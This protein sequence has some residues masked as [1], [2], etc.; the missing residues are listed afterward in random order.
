MTDL[1]NNHESDQNSVTRYYESII[2][3]VPV[4]MVSYDLNLDITKCNPAFVELTGYSKDRL[5]SMNVKDF[6]FTKV[7][8]NGA[9][10]AIR[11]KKKVLAKMWGTF[12]SGKKVVNTYTLPIMDDLGKVTSFLGVYIDVTDVAELQNKNE[13]LIDENPCAILVLDEKKNVTFLNKAFSKITG[14]SR[15]EGLRMNMRSFNVTKRDGDDAMKAFQ[16]GQ[17]AHGSLTLNCP[18]GT[19]YLEN[20]YLP[21]VGSDG[22]I[23]EVFTVFLDLTKER[24]IQHYME[25]EIHEMST[26][27]EMIAQGDLTIRYELTK[28]DADTQLTHDQI[29]KLHMSVRAILNNLKT[30]IHD[31]NTRMEELVTTTEATNT[32]LAEVSNGAHSAATSVAK[33]SENSDKVR[34]NVGQVLK[35][36]EDMSAAIEEVT[37]NM[38]AASTLAKS[39]NDLS[40][41]GAQNAGKAGESMTKITSSTRNVQTIVNDISN[42]M[43]EIVK[44]VGLIRDLA[45][46]TNLLALNAAIEAARAGDAGRGFAVVAAEV[47]SLA[48]ESRNSA[49]NIEEM[50]AGLRSKSLEAAKAMEESGKVVEEGSGVLA[51]TLSSFNEIVTAVEK[52][53]HNS[54]EVASAAGEQAATVEEI[55]ASVHEVANLVDATAKDASEVAAATEEAS[56]SITEIGKMVENVSKVAAESLTANKKFKVA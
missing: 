25:H 46:Q 55:T 33:V 52:I 16:E 7:E 37:S 29:Y 30:N 24:K 40:K 45:S 39:T 54:E 17:I 5:L 47:K 36:M 26:R 20:Y 48:Q 4:S 31:V 19:K 1:Q 21:V 50:I 35:A 32:G 8:G 23:R 10:D 42:E 6:T 3:N 14:Y 34:L 41:K 28:P 22:S 27:Y 51:E 56:A 12:P 15:E 13:T 43:N 11:T 49:E 9:A 53:S 38:E 44:I 18:L 2:Q